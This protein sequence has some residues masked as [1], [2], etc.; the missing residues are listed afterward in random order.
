MVLAQSTQVLIQFLHPFFMRLQSFFLQPV[1]QSLSPHLFMSSLSLSLVYLIE[2]VALSV[3]F[4]VYLLNF[5]R[6]CLMFL[7]KC[8]LH[9]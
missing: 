8:G 5:T 6:Y 7:Q 9:F 4:A 2:L 3:Y 1:V